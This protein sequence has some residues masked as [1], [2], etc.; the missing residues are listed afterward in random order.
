MGQRLIGEKRV[1]AQLAETDALLNKYIKILH[2]SEDAARLIFDEGWYGAEADEEQIRLEELAAEQR[3]REAAR[4]RELAEKRERERREREEQER[5]AREEKE[6][7]E[8]AKKDRLS[9]RGGV[10]GVRGTRAS[11][12]GMRAAAPS[13]RPGSIS[14]TFLLSQR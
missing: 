13:S 10:R 9:S 4:E 1:A 14:S 12:R 3:A 2:K 7:I 6:R 11:M 5:A 8:Q